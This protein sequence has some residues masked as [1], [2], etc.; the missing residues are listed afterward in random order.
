MIPCLLALGAHL[1]GYHLLWDTL[2]GLGSTRVPERLLPI[3]CL[4]IAALV[5]L[6]ADRALVAIS[7][8]RRRVVALLAAAVLVLALDLRVPVFGAVSADRPSRRVRGDPR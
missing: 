2:P 5:A 7:H 4:A 6:A 8:K 3:A 1:P